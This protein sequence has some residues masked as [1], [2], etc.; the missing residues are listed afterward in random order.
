MAG[1]GQGRG[2]GHQT[3]QSVGATLRQGPEVWGDQRR[4]G[5]E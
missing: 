4:G 5:R 2:K 1:Q 3:L